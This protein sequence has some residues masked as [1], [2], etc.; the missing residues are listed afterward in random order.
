MCEVCPICGN[1][2]M[3]EVSCVLFL[4]EQLSFVGKM[5]AFRVVRRCYVRKGGRPWELILAVLMRWIHADIDFSDWSH[6]LG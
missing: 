3:C 1:G 6:I 2:Q 5:E 4:D